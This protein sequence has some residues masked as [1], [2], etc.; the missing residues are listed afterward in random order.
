M[1]AG[2]VEPDAVPLSLRLL[3][4]QIGWAIFRI[5]CV[6][7]VLGSR[8]EGFRTLGSGVMTSRIYGFTSDRIVGDKFVLIDRFI[9]IF[10]SGDIFI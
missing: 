2:W 3:T 5:G 8:F 7:L 1:S 9:R 6:F 10:E 4:V